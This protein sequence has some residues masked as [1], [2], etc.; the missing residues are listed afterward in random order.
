MAPVSNES[1]DTGWAGLRTTASNGQLLLADGI[2]ATCARHVEDMLNSIV[3]VHAWIQ[4]NYRTAC[5]PIAATASGLQ[6]EAVFNRKIGAEL[7]QRMDQH[8]T[9]L[10]DMGNTFVAAGKA[11]QDAES[12]SAAAFGGTRTS[13]AGI[14]FTGSK[15]TPPA[16]DP[17]VQAMPPAGI[18]N[19]PDTRMDRVPILLERAAN[20]DW[21]RLYKIGQSI[22]P[23]AVAN[24]GGVWYW[25]A[26]C[27]LAPAFDTFHQNI[28]AV[29]DQW[30]GK[31]GTAAIA[32]TQNY[33]TASK[34]L[35]DNMNKL[36]D[37]LIYTA[38]WLQQTKTTMPQQPNPPVTNGSGHASTPT[39]IAAATRPYQDAF[40]AGYTNNVGHTAGNVVALPQPDQVTETRPSNVRVLPPLSGGPE[41]QPSSGTPNNG[42]RIEFA[43]N[44]TD[45]PHGPLDNSDPAGGN[46]PASAPVTS[47]PGNDGPPA[48]EGS[49]TP[50][51]PNAPGD[52]GT[53]PS[54]PGTPDI[55]TTPDPSN[56]LNDPANPLNDRFTP[57]SD[58]SNPLDGSPTPFLATP[59]TGAMAGEA[60]NAEK[61]LLSALGGGAGGGNPLAAEE[62]LL[63][64]ESRL[65]PRSSLPPAV[66][67]PG[68]AGPVEGGEP[69]LPMAGARSGGKDQ[70]KERKRSE[71]LNSTQHLD[72]ALGA[73]ARSVRP[74]LDR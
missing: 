23:Q 43:A 16:G 62:K 50:I 70:E 53:P 14:S 5:P 41:T 32:A 9:I 8:R 59:L 30:I 34:A 22:A 69:G 47:L 67:P 39:D 1:D 28:S 15:G 18:P 60:A 26:Q 21:Q 3:G 42:P 11:Y 37:L 40:T 29:R 31:G 7:A 33:T 63:E 55:S 6:L 2:A 71:L 68:R 27:V 52:G 19:F 48:N 49:S 72:E 51:D 25:L 20:L 46:I 13:F 10:T 54:T 17:F 4:Q 24:A 61:S 58:T 36:G 64:Q 44:G 74:V 12:A 65:F 45:G 35:T 57:R 56:P 66:E 73:V 38:D